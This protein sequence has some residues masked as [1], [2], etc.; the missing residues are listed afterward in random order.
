MDIIETLTNSIY[1]KMV[2]IQPKIKPNNE[3]VPFN[4]ENTCLEISMK[5]WLFVCSELMLNE[6]YEVIKIDNKE[7][8]YKNLICNTKGLLFRLI[9]SNYLN[10]KI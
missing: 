8:E 4:K 6:Q 7:F 9:N 10:I 2:I 5:D 1:T 3:P